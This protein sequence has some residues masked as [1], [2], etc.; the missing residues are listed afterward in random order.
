[1]SLLGLRSDVAAAFGDD[2]AKAIAF[3]RERVDILPEGYFKHRMQAR[4]KLL[5]EVPR[6]AFWGLVIIILVA[7]GLL[8]FGKIFLRRV[9]IVP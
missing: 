3:L 6:E 8:V 7:L 4:V 2:R 9:W 5:E 1:M